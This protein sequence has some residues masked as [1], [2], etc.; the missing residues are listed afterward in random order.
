MFSSIMS[1][2][3]YKIKITISYKANLKFFQYNVGRPTCAVATFKKFRLALSKPDIYSETPQICKKL[4]EKI[5]SLLQN[6]SE[7]YPK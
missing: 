7:I 4:K 6:K 1:V 2:K 5:C 3:I